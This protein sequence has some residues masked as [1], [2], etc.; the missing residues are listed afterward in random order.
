MSVVNVIGRRDSAAR[1]TLG[2]LF[3]AD[4]MRAADQPVAEDRS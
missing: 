2:T 4:P 3:R 1:R